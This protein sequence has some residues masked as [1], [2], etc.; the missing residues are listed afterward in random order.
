I[1]GLTNPQMT[2]KQ[3]SYFATEK[4]VMTKPGTATIYASAPSMQPVSDS[5]TL[6]NEAVP[7]TLQVY[8]YPPIVNVNQNAQSYVIVQLHDSAGN[9]VIAKEDIPV[10]VRVVNPNDTTIV[11]TSGQSPLV[12]ISDSLVIKKGSYWGYIPV[13]F[14]SG[15]NSAK[16][17]V[18]ISAKGFVISTTP[19]STT[20]TTSVTS[21]TGSTVP[22]S[23]TSASGTTTTTSTTSTTG[24][25]N[26]TSTTSTTGTTTSGNTTATGTATARS[27]ATSICSSNPVKLSTSQVQI[28]TVAQNFVMDDKTPCFYPLPILTT[29]NNE[30]IGVMSLKDP[31]GYPAL[32]KSNLSFQ[33]D[34]SDPSTVSIPSVDMGYGDQ[35]A[36]VFAQ[37]GNAANPVMFNTASNSPQQITPIIS[38]SSQTSSGLTASPLL[39]TVLPNTQFPLAIYAT[40]N[41]ALGSFG[42]GFTALISPQESISPIQLTV[43]KTDPIFLTEETLLKGGTQNIAITTPD[44]TS[45]FTVVGASTKP[46]GVTLGYPD[47]ITSNSNLLF[48]VELLDDKQLPIL[49]SK[50][51]DIK[52]ISSD[53]S[54]LDVP[55]TVQIKQ[56]SYYAT[57][58]AHSMQGGTAEIAVLAD[59]IPLSKFDITSTSYTPVAK[60]DSADHADN[61]SPVTATLTATY[62][63]APVPD[64]V[65]DW[66]VTG[67]TIQKKDS[68]TGTDGKATISLVTNNPDSVKIQASVGGGPYQTVTATKQISINP[69]LL[70]ASSS[71]QPSQ[72]NAPQTGFTVMGMNPILFIIPGAA[73]AAFVVL[74]KKNML[75]GISEKINITDKFSGIK[76]R[77][78][79]SQEN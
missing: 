12:Q 34:S 31:S 64:L 66:Q 27:T 78:S 18:D 61:N 43:T 62:K 14:T 65:V 8:A 63:T 70:P 51:M 46:S 77:M 19:I 75:E 58:D 67:G 49:A 24:I 42:N 56:G 2:I 53:P 25:T 9:P 33:I 29:G 47:Q 20:V 76:G 39:Q 38:S 35:S 44:Y 52:L 37:I 6:N 30:L 48:S 79:S 28:S 26:T 16:Y 36:L 60:I 4:F 54:V 68:V 59:G 72:N 71:G 57:F 11:N 69:P 5:V 40:K 50:D 32:A 17:D 73:A 21:N 13:E 74:K 55:D 3:G 10:S 1:A 41:S 7:Y 22:G 45:T 23:T 15:V